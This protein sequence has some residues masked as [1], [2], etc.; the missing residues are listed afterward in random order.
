M[1]RRAPWAASQCRPASAMGQVPG[2]A[3]G[4][5]DLG[6]VVV[7]ADAESEAVTVAGDEGGDLGFEA[8]H[9]AHGVGQ[10]EGLEPAGQAGLEHADECRGS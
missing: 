4:L 10:D 6:A 2:A 3:L 1:A 9:G 8:A 7:E 5:V